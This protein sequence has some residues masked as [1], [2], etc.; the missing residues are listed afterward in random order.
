MQLSSKNISG[1][2]SKFNNQEK[3]NELIDNHG[4]TETL[5]RFFRVSYQAKTI[6][7]ATALSE[8]IQKLNDEMYLEFLL[9]IKNNVDEIN[10]IYGQNNKNMQHR[11]NEKDE[12]LF[13]K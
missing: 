2:D 8:E 4:F 6:E 7:K 12:Q 11:V 10:R 5:D 3:F 9:G 13:R 1:N